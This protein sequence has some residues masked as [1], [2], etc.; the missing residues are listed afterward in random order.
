MKLRDT[1]TRYVEAMIHSISEVNI[2]GARLHVHGQISRSNFA[3][4]GLRSF[5]DSSYIGFS[6]DYSSLQNCPILKTAYQYL[7]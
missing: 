1:C 7:T 4:I 2:D 3:L 6:F 5:V